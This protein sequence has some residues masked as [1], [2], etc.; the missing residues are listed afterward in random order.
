MI[1]KKK[2]D[3]KCPESEAATEARVQSEQRLKETREDWRKV[4]EVT[5]SLSRLRRTN[6]F[7][8]MIEKAMRHA[9]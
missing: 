7:A 4:R 9:P 1:F 6:H 5:D 8:E 3:G 2:K